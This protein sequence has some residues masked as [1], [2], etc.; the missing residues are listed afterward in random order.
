MV[1]HKDYG[2]LIKKQVQGKDGKM[3]TVYVDPRKGVE[4][5][6][7]AAL[8]QRREQ[9]SQARGPEREQDRAKQKE[10]AGRFRQ[11]EQALEEQK[12]R[13]LQ[14]MPPIKGAIMRIYAKGK[15]NVGGMIAQVQEVVGNVARVMLP[16]GTVSEVPFDHLEFA[17]AQ[18]SPAEELKIRKALE[19]T[20]E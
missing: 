9:L 4:V 13:G 11:F 6:R 7:E 8:K 15:A 1:T 12:R 3:H 16:S 5:P 20:D 2:K 17:K 10:I 19:M 18:Y 14:K